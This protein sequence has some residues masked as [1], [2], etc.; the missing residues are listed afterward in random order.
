MV[1]GYI[2]TPGKIGVV[3]RSGTLTYEVCNEMST[4]RTSTPT[5]GIYLHLVPCAGCCS[6]S[7]PNAIYPINPHET[8][9]Q[10]AQHGFDPDS[11]SARLRQQSDC[12]TQS[13][14]HILYDSTTCTTLHQLAAPWLMPWSAAC[15][16]RLFA[17]ASV[18]CTSERCCSSSVDES[19]TG[20]TPNAARE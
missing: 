19:D 10:P 13:A 2:H 11:H 12:S 8:P 3:S 6:V 15:L 5:A 4:A 16:P 18:A 7:P 20:A 1:Q 9:S 17:Q 14:A